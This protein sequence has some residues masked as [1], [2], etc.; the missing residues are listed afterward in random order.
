MGDTPFNPLD[1]SHLAESLAEA[2]LRRPI[3][4][5]PPDERFKGAGVYAIY[6]AGG[7]EIYEPIASKNRVDNP[8]LPIYVGKAVPAG[9]RKGGFGLGSDPG[10]ALSKRLKEHARSIEE[11]DNLHLNDFLCRY[12]VCDDIWIPLGE[13]LLIERFKPLWNV[14]IEGFGIHTP[15]KGRRRQVRSKWDTLHPGRTLTKGLPANP[16][17]QEEIA[18]L[19]SGFLAGEKVPVLSTREAIIEEAV[20]QDDSEEPEEV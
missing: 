13:S 16:Q 3:G 20:E 7:L 17:S 1:K 10:S 14:L 9:A 11:A 2:L 12:L 19:V 5:L 15:G 6:Y 8:N 4:P 18:R